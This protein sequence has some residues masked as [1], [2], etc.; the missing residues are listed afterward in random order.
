M[1]AH[2]DGARARTEVLWI[3]PAVCAAHGLFGATA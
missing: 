3:N 2:A 1:A